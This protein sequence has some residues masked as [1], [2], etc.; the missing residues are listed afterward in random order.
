MLAI[1]FAAKIDKITVSTS[2][3]VAVATLDSL[4]TRVLLEF[5]KL[6][7]SPTFSNPTLG[8]PSY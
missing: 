5:N 1:F 3:G 6:S 8:K 7:I 4:L 2:S